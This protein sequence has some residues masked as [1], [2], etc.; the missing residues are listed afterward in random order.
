MHFHYSCNYTY[1]YI[2]HNHY[3]HHEDNRL[4]HLPC[5]HH[6]HEQAFRPADVQEQQNRGET[7][8]LPSRFHCKGYTH[9]E[10][11]N[12]PFHIFM[13]DD[14]YDYGPSCARPSQLFSPC[15]LSTSKG[16]AAELPTPLQLRQVFVS[17]MQ[18]IDHWRNRGNTTRYS[19]LSL[20]IE[21]HWMA[22]MMVVRVDGWP[23]TWSTSQ[24]DNVVKAMENLKCREEE[25]TIIL[26]NNVAAFNHFLH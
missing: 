7:D 1:L 23:L 17:P 13:H 5:H 4:N 20:M 22:V 12:V 16:C 18:W 6:S 10:A 3:H 26:T 9:P 24:V 11:H 15:C 25:V 8:C 2:H 14:H 21:C 19:R